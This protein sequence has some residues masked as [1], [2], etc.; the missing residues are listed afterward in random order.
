MNK[1]SD[2]HKKPPETIKEVGIHIGYMREDI[3]DLKQFLKDNQYV[4]GKEF[5][6]YKVD[7]AEEHGALR[8]DIDHLLNWKEKILTR[9]SAGAVVF[10]VVLVL[11]WYGL[12][13][14]LT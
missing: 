5:A 2:D 13:K 14:F 4:T 3:L 9:I 6:D 1:M 10:I 12:D 7:A 11:A 8:R